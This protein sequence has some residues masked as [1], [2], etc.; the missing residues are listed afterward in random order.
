MAGIGDN[1]FQHVCS[2]IR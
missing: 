2:F 1:S